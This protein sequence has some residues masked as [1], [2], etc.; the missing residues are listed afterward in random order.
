MKYCKI[1][2]PKD[3]II[4]N[5][6]KY[7][8]SYE[9]SPIL[10]CVFHPSEYKNNY[11]VKLKMKKSVSLLLALDFYTQ[12][13]PDGTIRSIPKNIFKN[14][15]YICKDSIIEKCRENK[16]DGIFQIHPIK[17]GDSEILLINDSEIYEIQ[18]IKKY[19]E[20][21]KICCN[22]DNPKIR[23]KNWG[24]LY[25]NC[26]IKDHIILY[27]ND[28]YKEYIDIFLENGIKNRCLYY[29]CIYLLFKNSEII[30]EKNYIE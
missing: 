21:W 23:Y 2:L 6:Q 27:L 18:D 14:E 16:I 10:Y 20:D 1:I 29:K 26:L 13:E 30:Y 17:T 28:I 8:K 25:P 19:E 11:I 24:I 3:C 9:K 4:Y 15:D 12:Y 22:I 7:N 5:T